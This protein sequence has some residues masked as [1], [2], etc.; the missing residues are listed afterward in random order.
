MHSLHRLP[1]SELHA[2]S[3]LNF[4]MILLILISMSSTTV[5]GS[6]ETDGS[7]GDGDI[8]G[9]IIDRC[10]A[11]PIDVQDTATKKTKASH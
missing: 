2:E 11:K 9:R 5:S 7:D 3:Y 10:D 6:P 1:Y 8:R 4:F